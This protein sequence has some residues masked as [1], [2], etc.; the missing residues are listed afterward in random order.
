MNACSGVSLLANVL[1]RGALRTARGVSRERYL[2]SR[3]RGSLFAGKHSGGRHASIP[4]AFYGRMLPFARESQAKQTCNI[5][6]QCV[7]TS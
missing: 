6:G 5:M 3:H 4:S 1:A 7:L 2:Y